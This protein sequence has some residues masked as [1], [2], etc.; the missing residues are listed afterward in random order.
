[1]IVGSKKYVFVTLFL[2]AKY[3]KLC[4]LKLPSLSRYRKFYVLPKHDIIFTMVIKSAYQI[5]TN[6]YD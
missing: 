2:A 1:M 5:D 3:F 4:Q 6:L